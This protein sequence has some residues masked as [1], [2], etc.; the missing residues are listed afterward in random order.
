M[1]GPE[2]NNKY[3]FRSGKALLSDGT[4]INIFDEMMTIFGEMKVVMDKMNDGGITVVDTMEQHTHDGWAFYATMKFILPP[5]AEYHFGGR[6][7]HGTEEAYVHMQDRAVQVIS[8]A[9]TTDVSVDL[10]EDGE[11]ENGTPVEI[12]NN[13]RQYDLTNNL[14]DI[15]DDVDVISLGNDIQR[16]FDL[17]A[18]K[19]SAA[20][21]VSTQEYVMKDNSDY[22][23][24][25]TNN[26]VAGSVTV[27]IH[28]S[29]YCHIKGH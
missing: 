6:A 16:G 29:W 23:L 20:N 5:N 28:W 15:W 14:F 26:Q 8:G 1:A 2:R 3:S 11:F 12:F 25:I 18:E 27:I 10:F 4:E 13:N 24:R 7:S 19:N 9:Q 21:T 22:L 17:K